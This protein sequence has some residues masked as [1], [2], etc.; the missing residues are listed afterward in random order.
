MD[1]GYTAIDIRFIPSAVLM[2]TVCALVMLPMFALAAHIFLW[3]ERSLAYACSAIN[4]LAA[5]FAGA[6]AMSV[7]KKN[8]VLTALVAGV[9]II[10][11]LFTIAFLSAGDAMKV[12]GILSVVS[13]TLAGALVGA[14]FFPLDRKKT[15]RKRHDS[16]RKK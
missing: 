8:A 9:C 2:W 3:S 12:D 14:V 16:R 5:V 11:T 13:F 15:F 7:R 4:F 1:K 6:K 10:I